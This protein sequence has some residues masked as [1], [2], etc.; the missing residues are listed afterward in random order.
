M[1]RL[2]GRIGLQAY[3]SA[4]HILLTPKRTVR[5]LE[6]F[7]NRPP[8]RGKQNDLSF[9]REDQKNEQKLY[10]ASE[11]KWTQMSSFKCTDKQW[12]SCY[13]RMHSSIKRDRSAR[14][15]HEIKSFILHSTHEHITKRDKP[16]L[17]LDMHPYLNSCTGIHSSICMGLPFR[18]HLKKKKCTAKIKS[19]LQASHS[20]CS[21]C[22]SA[23]HM[24]IWDCGELICEPYPLVDKFIVSRRCWSF[25]KTK[26]KIMK[27]ESVWLK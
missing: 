20:P 19:S 4:R 12:T 18:L 26:P 3:L 15:G 8:K 22:P 11:S 13:S 10:E 27:P 5:K 9:C 16:F 7:C 25:L 21:F 6:V 23:K 14:L 2:V 17:P 24:H 1:C